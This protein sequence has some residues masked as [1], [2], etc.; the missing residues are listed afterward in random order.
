MAKSQRPARHW[1]RV[2][3]AEIAPY[4]WRPW[5]DGAVVGRYLLEHD[6]PLDR[7]LALGEAITSLAAVSMVTILKT[8]SKPNGSCGPPFS[9]RSGRSSEPRR[10]ARSLSLRPARLNGVAPAQL[11]YPR[12]NLVFRCEALPATPRG[13]RGYPLPVRVSYSAR[14]SLTPRFSQSDLAA[15]VATLFQPTS[16]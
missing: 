9:L 2:V 8:G 7:N 4:V 1:G 5:R 11:R 14:V 16:R 15:A 10:K 6:G 12:V 13:P 3:E